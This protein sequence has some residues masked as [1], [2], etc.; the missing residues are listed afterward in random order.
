VR[1]EAEI[2]GR[3]GVPSAA[4]DASFSEVIGGRRPPSNT[5]PSSRPDRAA[6]GRPIASAHLS[7]KAGATQE[8]TLEAVRCSAR[9]CQNPLLKELALF[10]PATVRLHWNSA[11]KETS[12]RDATRTTKLR[13]GLS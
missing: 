2:K 13:T 10:P 4:R 1:G 12:L 7:P 11:F 9:L 6:S 5:S 3:S 8:R